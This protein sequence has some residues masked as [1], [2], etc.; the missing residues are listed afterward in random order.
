MQH[1][2]EEIN[3]KTV[4]YPNLDMVDRLEEVF[5]NYGSDVKWGKDLKID[6][7]TVMGWRHGYHIPNMEMLRRICEISG[8]SADEILGLRRQN[9]K[10]D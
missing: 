3:I 8:A 9:G 6:R 5:V 4:C 2:K 1:W 7:K 10:I